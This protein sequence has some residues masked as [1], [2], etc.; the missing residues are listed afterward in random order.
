MHCKIIRVSKFAHLIK[1]DARIIERSITAS[2][3]TFLHQDF[4]NIENNM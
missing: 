4:I 1:R 3:V 2:P